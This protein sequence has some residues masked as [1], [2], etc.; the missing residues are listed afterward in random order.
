MPN[1]LIHET[2]PYLLQHA[3]N[4]VDWFPWGKEALDRAKAEDRPI[5][6]SIG[7][8]AC[9]WCHVMERESFEDP[10]IAR[11]MNEQFICIKVDREERPDLDAIY[12]QAVQTMTGRG[13]WPLTV[14]LT[15][16]AKPF[17]GGT[18]FPPQD[19]GGMAGFPRILEAIAT[20]Y[21]Q[22]KDQVFKAANDLTRGIQVAATAQHASDPLTQDLLRQAYD[23]IASRF[24]EQHAGFGDAPKFPQA[25]PL[26]YLLRYHH[27]TGDAHALEMVERTLQAMAYGG[28]NDQLG[29]GFHRYSTDSEW[30]APHFEKM[31]YDNAQLAQLYL[32]AYQLTGHPLYRRVAEET[33][34]YLLREMHHPDGGF[35]TSQDADS[36]G[37]EGKY[38]LWG[39]V[40]VFDTL[41]DDDADLFCHYYGVTTE[42]NFEGENI[43][44]VPIAPVEV[45]Q[46]LGTT[47]EALLA[48]LQPS[49]ERLR[50]ERSHR[51]PPPTDDK[52]ITAW[53][54]LT[55]RALAQAASIFNN[56]TYRK[57]AKENGAFLLDQLYRDGRLLRTWKDGRAHLK[58]YLDDY[59]FLVLGL[60]SLHEATF[61]HRWLRAAQQLTDEMLT[62][63]WDPEQQTL[64][65]TGND[66]EELV[67]RPREVFDNA[68]PSGNSAAAEALLRIAILTGDQEYRRKAALLLESVTS[69]LPV[70]A[71]GFGHW[72]NAL[73]L[74]LTGPQELGIVGAPHQPAT[75]ALLQT[76]HSKFLPNRVLVGRDPGDPDIFPTPILEQRDVVNGSPTAY[77]CHGYVCELPTGDPLE[78]ARQLSA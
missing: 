58:A 51:T 32:E 3:H 8:A 70:Y 77:V 13:G 50:E 36:E 52:V 46:A 12:M 31:L 16:E 56:E 72:L 60:L 64:F 43:L 61:S 41:G 28:I 76:V 37:V 1:Q 19:L 63:F 2:S 29:G 69:Y 23:A 49:R 48:Q 66:H 9:H 30:L 10:D 44:C 6:I 27:R 74:Y 71:L 67:V 17:F 55:L 14:F 5:L 20:A 39:P 21:A 7:Y 53:N 18:Y 75:K 45:A 40:E 59:A 4:P 42:G 25:M 24:D 34:D 65:D 78:L 11:Q 54:A 33:L 38:Y 26:E 62:I 73:D 68:T 15:P 22:H 47:E 57:A 35:Y